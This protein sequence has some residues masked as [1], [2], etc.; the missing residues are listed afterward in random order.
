[1]SAVRS[2]E[3]VLPTPRCRSSVSPSTT[4]SRQVA[5]VRSS[6]LPATAPPMISASR[7]LSSPPMSAD[8]QQL[9]GAITALE[10]QRALLGDAVVDAALGTMRA[11]LAAL[12]AAP[13]LEPEQQLTQVSIL[14]LDVVGSTTL[15]QHIDPEAISA[16]MD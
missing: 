7:L 10:S 14:F 16:V 2:G 9:E 13:P 15:S 8:Q 3:L 6:G 1:M 4:A 5:D 12:T 11:A